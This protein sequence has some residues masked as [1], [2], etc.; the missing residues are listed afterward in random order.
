M[1][2]NVDFSKCQLS[3]DKMNS[4]KLNCLVIQSF[5]EANLSHIETQFSDGNPISREQ[6]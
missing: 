6:L 1:E 3:V 2:V 5:N 4:S